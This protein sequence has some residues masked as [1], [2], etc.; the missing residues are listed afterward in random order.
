MAITDKIFLVTTVILMTLLTEG[1]HHKENTP[2]LYCAIFTVVEMNIFRCVF[3]YFAPKI[4]CGYTM[5]THNL[6]FRSK[7]RKAYTPVHPSFTIYKFGVRGYKSHEHVI[8]IC[9]K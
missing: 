9:N 7:I 8:L 6:C 1:K 5:S 2:M 4:D 3:P